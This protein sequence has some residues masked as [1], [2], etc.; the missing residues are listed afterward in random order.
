MTDITPY[1]MHTR[2]QINPPISTKELA[3][4]LLEES[5][6]ATATHH[7]IY[8]LWNGRSL[9]GT[10]NLELY[11]KFL[12]LLKPEILLDGTITRIEQNNFRW[13][14][15]SKKILLKY[16]LTNI[17]YIGPRTGITGLIVS[18]KVTSDGQQKEKY[19][20]IKKAIA[21]KTQGKVRLTWENCSQTTTCSLEDEKTFKNFDS[22]NEKE[23]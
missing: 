17:A 22:K 6:V 4:C 19:V 16:G 23:A 12:N 1:E 14:V 20:A 13:S 9:Y 18:S 8:V 7:R 2:V 5:D 21:K 15:A 11:Q 3:S 10:E